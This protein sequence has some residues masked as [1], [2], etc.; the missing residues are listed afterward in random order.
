[1]RRTVALAAAAAALALPALAVAFPNTEP[2]AAKQWYLTQDKAWDFWPAL[3]DLYPVKV[4]VIDSGID[5][6]HPDLVG[7]VVAAKSFVGGSPFDDTNGHGTFVAG[8]IAA[9]PTNG[10]GI[11]GLAFNARLIDAKV[12][13][14]QGE[15]S[16]PAEVAAIRWS[17]AEGAKVINLSLGGLR[18]PLNPSL[19]TYS[20]L[21][22]AAIEYAVSKGVVV[23]A[24]VGNGTQS[25]AK[26]WNFATYPAALPHVIGVSADTE[27]GAVPAYS[28]RD[29][30][31]NDI[32]APG[33]DIFSTIPQS[34]VPEGST[35]ADG[36]YSDCGPGDFHPAI[37]TSFSAPQ[38]SAAAALLLGQDPMLTPDQV[39][40]LLERSAD[41]ANASTGCSICPTGRDAD[42]GWGTLDV[43]AALTL[44]TSGAPLPRPDAY[45]PNDDAGPWSHAIPALPTTIAASLDYWDDNVD[46]YRVYLHKGQQLFA[47]LTP[48]AKATVRLAL[49]PPGTQHV[50]G[51]AASSKRLAQSR[52]V[53]AQARLSYKVKKT[54]TYYVEAKLVSQSRDPVQYRLSVS[55][56]SP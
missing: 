49:W 11:A 53:G 14:A 29:A 18:D 46:V 22:Q 2:L 28:N 3:P 21:E 56:R 43:D 20:P 40:F 32:S 52:A 26:P 50:E 24:A 36:A 15:V 1:V 38:V 30:I 44:L 45:E 25:P 35:C 39:S 48:A 34:L 31:Y 33:D 4:A 41:D 54:G 37:G 7:R 27:T 51:L 17:V 23:V 19:D 5:N 47:R 10:I 55:R 12:V 6:S 9:N 13:T 42:T 16:L 8:E